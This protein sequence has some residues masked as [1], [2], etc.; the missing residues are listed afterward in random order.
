MFDPTAL[1]QAI[2]A[3]ERTLYPFLSRHFFAY[4]FEFDALVGMRGAYDYS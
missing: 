4:F 3:P 1:F 2:G